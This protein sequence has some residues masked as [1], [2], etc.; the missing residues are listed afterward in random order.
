MKGHDTNEP[1]V[2]R[3][4]HKLIQRSIMK[5]LLCRLLLFVLG[6]AYMTNGDKEL[7]IA[8]YKKSL[9]LDPSNKNGEEALK[10]LMGK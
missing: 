7:A 6:E 9:E 2:P 8:S 10:K 1:H 4:L 5:R 3:S